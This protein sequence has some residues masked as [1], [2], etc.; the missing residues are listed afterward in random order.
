MTKHEYICRV[1]DV[2]R[3]KS[4]CLKRKVGAVFVN[5]DFEILATGYNAPP[6]KF[7]HCDG[8]AT[9]HS[10]HSLETG[11]CDRNIHAEINGIVQ[12]AKRGTALTGSTLYCTYCPCIGC[13][14][15][16]I[17]LNVK[18]VFVKDLDQN[19]SGLET[20]HEAWI[21]VFPWVPK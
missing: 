18:K 17:N 9:C 2:V 7:Q 12:A 14:R 20:L 11:S 1:C 13:A 6:K 5:A 16:L 19:T 15:A 10:G 3:E 21:G 8:G 4:D